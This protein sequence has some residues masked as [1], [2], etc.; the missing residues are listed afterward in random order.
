M[1]YNQRYS[2]REAFHC[3]NLIFLDWSKLFHIHVD[4]SSIVLGVVLTQQGEENI[5]H[6]VYFSSHMLSDVK[7]NYMTIEHE[8]LAMLYTL[9]KIHH[10]MLGFDFKLFTDH[11]TLNYLANKLV[12]GGRICRWLF[13]FQEFYFEVMVK[14]RKYNVGSDHLS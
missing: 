7:N 13:L 4:A 8:G 10:Y 2:Q 5:D 14:P 3:A 6:L 12:L 1:L 11:S 9:Q